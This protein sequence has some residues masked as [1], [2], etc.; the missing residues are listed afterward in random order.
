MIDKL[1]CP[2]N[3]AVTVVFNF[4]INALKRSIDLLRMNLHKIG[5]NIEFIVKLFC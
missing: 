3:I 2:E 4:I 1:T 5:T